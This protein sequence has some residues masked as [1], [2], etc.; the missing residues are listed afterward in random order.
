M[1]QLGVSQRLLDSPD[2]DA[3]SSESVTPVSEAGHFAAGEPIGTPISRPG[4]STTDLQ[5]LLN[6]RGIGQCPE[7]LPVMPDLRQPQD[8]SVERGLSSSASLGALGL[9]V[10]TSNSFRHEALPPEVF[11]DEPLSPSKF[12]FLSGLGSSNSV[13]AKEGNRA[14]SRVSSGNSRILVPNSAV[15][16]DSF[17]HVQIFSMASRGVC[18]LSI[19]SSLLSH[20]QDGGK[21]GLCFW[22]MIASFAYWQFLLIPAAT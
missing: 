2:R 20:L 5:E 14:L 10:N 21:Q 4:V 6:S 8:S 9:P 7:F 19:S 12:P 16:Y 15:G 13:A 17:C 1:Q 22:C 3:A 11:E 18:D